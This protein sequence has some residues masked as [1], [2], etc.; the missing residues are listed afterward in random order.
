MSWLEVDE[1]FNDYAEVLQPRNVAEYLATQDWACLADKPFG[2]LW[3]L[4]DQPTGQVSS[5]MLP[6]D[7]AA[8]DYYRRINES[9]TLLTRIL[10]LSASELAEAVSTVHADLF[11]VRVDQ[12]MKDGTI[13]LKQATQLL[14]NIDQM[15]KSAALATYNPLHSGLGKIPN[16]VKDFLDE[17]IRMGHTKRGSFI[18]TVAARHDQLSGS[19]ANSAPT[20]PDGVDEV[21]PVALTYTRRVMT[22]LS[23]ALDATRRH[24]ARGNDFMALD[25]AVHAGVRLPLIEA[26][27]DMGST[28]GLR[29]LDMT[30][31][32]SQSQP[33]PELDVPSEVIFNVD[34]LGSLDDVSARLRREVVPKDETLVGPVTELRRPERHDPNNDSGEI[35]V[36]ADVEGRLRKVR[37][38]LAGEDYDWA[39]VAHRER[40]PFTVSGTL[41]KKSNSWTLTG[42]VV[43]DT[44]FL[45]H[46][47]SETKPPLG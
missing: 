43:A 21:P 6:K 32:W 26:L 34:S 37:V 10:D 23:T 24:V 3:A 1:R 27:S 16:T 44:S 42:N 25:E 29:A 36:R 17:D 4:P 7:P 40:L 28:K 22:T 45:K 11:F 41:G 2:Q 15:I 38:E 12:S 31:N 46:R 19:S 9:L 13:P 39:I 30:F 47:L 8:V 18:I 35:I 33:K 5:I 20:A 14:E